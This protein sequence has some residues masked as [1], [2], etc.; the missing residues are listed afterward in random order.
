MWLGTLLFRPRKG[1]NLPLV[2]RSEYSTDMLTDSHPCSPVQSNMLRQVR[3]RTYFHDKFSFDTA[4][5]EY[6]LESLLVTQICLCQASNLAFLHLHHLG[7]RNAKFEIRLL[8]QPEFLWTT[9]QESRKVYVGLGGYGQ[10]LSVLLQIFLIN[11]QML[12]RS[13]IFQRSD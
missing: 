12:L 5:V 4:P 7:N 10:C 3:K 8:H 6:L 13:D 2:D 9:H 1:L 11:L